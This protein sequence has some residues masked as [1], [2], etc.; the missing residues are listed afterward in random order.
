MHVY[1]S[2]KTCAP[3]MP[4]GININTRIFCRIVVISINRNPR[5]THVYQPKKRELL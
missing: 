1:V 5:G 4:V 3:L 2:T